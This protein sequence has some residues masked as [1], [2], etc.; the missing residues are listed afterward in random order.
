MVIRRSSSAEIRQL[1]EALGAADDVAT[2]SAVARLAVI[3]PRATEHLL[4]EFPSATG[5]VRAGMLRAFEAAAD[6][7]TLPAARA[8]LQDGSAMVQ[9]AAIGA[10]RVLLSST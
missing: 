3:G 8:A 2:E 7:R 1:V 10:V 4:Q 9:S 6:P 5:R